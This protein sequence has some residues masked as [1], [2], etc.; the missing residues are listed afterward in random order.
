MSEDP[1]VRL[2]KI[3]GIG[4]VSLGVLL[5]LFRVLL[6]RIK[7]P[8]PTKAQ[9]YRI[10]LVFMVLVWSI[11][12]LGIIVWW[13]PRGPGRAQPPRVPPRPPYRVLWVDD[14]LTDER[15]RLI[16]DL[17]Q[18]QIEVTTE[19]SSDAARAR[20]QDT[21]FDLL[22]TDPKRQGDPN[23]GFAF[24][25]EVKQLYEGMPIVVY[26]NS[27]T[28][29]RRARAKQ[30][31]IDIANRPANLLDLVKR[32]LNIPDTIPDQAPAPS[33]AAP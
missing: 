19:P 1:L 31:G 27:L 12:V 15:Q 28:P 6:Q 24:A 18:L 23:A 7:F 21:P 26:C 3:A 8:P 16:A 25:E 4:G 29:E 30:L 22:I 2:G 14:R 13:V 9:A 32:K 17:R 20:M 33:A 5:I 10:I 11:A